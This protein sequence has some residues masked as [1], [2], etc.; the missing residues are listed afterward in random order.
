M[1]TILVKI[2]GR[3][4]L[5]MNNPASM[6]AEKV[7]RKMSAERNS[8]DDA[9]KTAYLNA[10]GKLFIPSRCMYAFVINSAKGFKLGKQSAPSL[11]AGSIS[12]EPFEIL[13]TPN[14]YEINMQR[15]VIQKNAVI[16][17]RAMLPKWEASFNLVYDENWISN[18]EILKQIIESG[19]VRVGLLDFRPQKHGQYG[20]F[21][22]VEW[23]EI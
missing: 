18:P 23:K 8:V 15:V 6:I 7:P 20:T 19:A 1:K 17:S 4:P 13:L 22:L 3:T 5:L 2:R 9:K 21:E 10:D 16:K 14:E 11:L 12:I